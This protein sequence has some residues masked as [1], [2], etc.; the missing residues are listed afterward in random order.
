[1]ADLGVNDVSYVEA[2]A[3]AKQ[4]VPVGRYLNEVTL[5]F[6]DGI[7]TYPSGGVPLTG[8][9][10]GFPNGVIESCIVW[11]GTVGLRSDWMFDSVN[12]TLR[13]YRVPSKSPVL[14]ELV[15]VTGNVGFLKQRPAHIFMVHASVGGVTGPCF[16]RLAN[17]VP[18]TTQ[19]AVTFQ[20]SKLTFAAGDAVTQCR[21]S[22]VPLACL[23]D[24]TDLVIDEVVTVAANVGLFANQACAVSLCESTAGGVVGINKFR[25]AGVVPATA[26]VAL[27]FTANPTSATFAAGDA[28]TA[29]RATYI[30]RR[31][32][33]TVVDE[34]ITLTPTAGNS[35]GTLAEPGIP[36][37]GVYHDTTATTVGT[38]VATRHNIVGTALANGT[39][40]IGSGIPQNAPAATL[41][42]AMNVH[43]AA[44]ATASKMTYIKLPLVGMLAVGQLNQEELRAGVD[45]VPATTL[46]VQVRGY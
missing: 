44:G 31:A 19:V 18:A 7:K 12:N 5:T 37:Y 6:G 8:A 43:D 15:V 27:D 30:K 9:G 22:Y 21:V 13:S 33:T 16:P 38:H 41:G 28:V 29:A 14:E 24:P 25:S 1:M 42:Q 26:Q 2:S 45:L 17:I 35:V 11:D 39:W 3:P 32:F 34:A 36:S 46:V 40:N 4:V 10:L 23:S 20:L